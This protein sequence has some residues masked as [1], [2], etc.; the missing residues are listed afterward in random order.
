MGCAY[1]CCWKS[2]L[3]EHPIIHA[4]T[5][6]SIFTQP[7]ATA[8]HKSKSLLLKSSMQFWANQIRHE[9]HS[10]GRLSTVLSVQ[11]EIKTR[12]S[13]SMDYNGVLDDDDDDKDDCNSHDH[14]I[15]LSSL[16][17]RKTWG[18]FPKIQTWMI[19]IMTNY[20][21]ILTWTFWQ[22]LSQL[23]QTI[24]VHCLCRVRN[25]LLLDYVIF[26]QQLN[27][28]INSVFLSYSL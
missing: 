27:C 19:L 9:Y 16:G 21:D 17:R 5:T 12:H 22:I 20:C 1:F 23:W 4:T 13:L 10:R 18:W 26:G 24:V 7:N 11:A 14:D 3:L 15:S 2:V 28:K 25:I 8:S 6:F